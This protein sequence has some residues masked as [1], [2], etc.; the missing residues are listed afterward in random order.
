MS[1][2]P[3][4]KVTT[5]C[6]YVNSILQSYNQSTGTPRKIGLHST[7]H[8]M[9][10]RDRIRI[11]S[12][13]MLEEQ[14]AKYLFEVWDALKTATVTDGADPARRPVYSQFLTLMSFH[15]FLRGVDAA[16]YEVGLGGELDSTNVIQNPQIQHKAGVFKRGC[17]AFTVQQIAP[18]MGRNDAS[19]AIALV[20]AVL[21]RLGL[22]L[23]YGANVFPEG[24]VRGL[25]SA[26]CRGRCKILTVHRT[27][28][29]KSRTRF[30]YALF[31]TNATHKGQL[32][33]PATLSLQRELASIWHDLDSNT[34]VVLVTRSVHLVG[35]A[36]WVLQ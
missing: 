28:Y 7:P 36:M 32:N 5:T 14:F 24:F 18:A 2:A 31:C 12:E 27:L 26:V 17:P 33:E 8:L 6:A 29:E 11:N 3:K 21:E 20:Q 19:L 9:Q 13:P 25:E 35:G 34:E 30:T 10:V 1:P 23:K 22:P 4:K 15:M 16:I